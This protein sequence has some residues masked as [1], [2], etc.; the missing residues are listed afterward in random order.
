MFFQYFG[1][2]IWWVPLGSYAGLTLGFSGTQIGMLYGTNALSAMLTP[3][4]VGALTD[5]YFSAQRVLALLFSLAGGALLLASNQTSFMGVFFCLFCAGLAFMPTIGI[6]NM[7]I[8]HRLEHPRKE[9]PP[10]RV[11][12]TF[13]W[14]VSGVIIGYFRLE[15]TFLPMRLGGVIFI[16]AGIA[17]LF[18]PDTPPY[19]TTPLRW[20]RMWGG[21][22]WVLFK[23]KSVVI[24]SI[25][26]IIVHIPV[27]FYYSFGNLYLTS[28][29]ME[30]AAAKMSLGQMSEM[31]FVLLLPWFFHRWGLKWV[32]ASGI[33]VWTLRFLFFIFG[34]LETGLWMIYVG[35]L[36]HGMGFAFVIL[37]GQI[38]ID[39]I[40][41]REIRA[42]AQS[43][44]ILLTSGLGLFIGSLVSGPVVK[45][46]TVSAGVYQWDKIWLVPV[47]SAAIALVP[48]L[49]FFK[50][51]K[52]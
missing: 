12:G 25:C 21:D 33:V 30:G 7:V 42:S 13:G 9:F 8:M 17:C 34:D 10:L 27:Q 5:R 14:I 19:K 50:E 51:E 29:G 38:Y 45:Y 28:S 23:N 2:G 22:A 6:T 36:S 40:A 52:G 1:M 41:P 43:L 31:V 18:L 37:A 35:I 44:V 47:I 16:F 20:S 15:Q 4:L 49:L 24:F 11:L 26:V 46:Y 48:F 39:Q 3:M 32:M